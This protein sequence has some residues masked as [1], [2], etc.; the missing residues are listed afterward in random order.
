M[1]ALFKLFS[2]IIGATL[3]GKNM[4]PMGS[5]FFPLIVV[6]FKTCFYAEKYYYSL[7]T[8]TNTLYDVCPFIACCVTEFETVFLDLIFW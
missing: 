7:D 5:I 1:N 8:D 4:L 2:I 6:P 3:K